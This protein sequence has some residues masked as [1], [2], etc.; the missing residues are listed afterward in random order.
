[1]IWKSKAFIF[2]SMSYFCIKISINLWE[3]FKNQFQKKNTIFD[4]INNCSGLKWS[5]TL[6]N[7]LKSLGNGSFLGCSG[8]DGQLFFNCS[9]T[10]ISDYA[11]YD[12][13]NFKGSLNLPPTIR[14]IG[15]KAFFNCYGFDESNKQY[16]INWWRCFS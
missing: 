9:L 12:C 6:S 8:F 7:S 1:M 16:W 11:F 10:K 4:W 15:S 2:Q 3:S 13:H 14:M 5:F